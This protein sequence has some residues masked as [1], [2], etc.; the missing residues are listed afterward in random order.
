AWHVPPATE[1]VTM[2]F[3]ILRTTSWKWRAPTATRPTVFTAHGTC[4]EVVTSR[5]VPVT[6]SP[7]LSASRSRQLRSGRGLLAEIDPSAR[8][9]AKARSPCWIVSSMAALPDWGEVEVRPE[10]PGADSVLRGAFISVPL[11]DR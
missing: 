5:S 4:A 11:H 10:V 1:I 2:P 8:P 9:A 6:V 7:V 3:G